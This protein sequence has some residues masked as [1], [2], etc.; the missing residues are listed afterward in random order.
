M[1]Q[2]LH[3]YSYSDNFFSLLPGETKEIEISFAREDYSGGPVILSVKGMNTGVQN[4][5]VNLEISSLMDTEQG[6]DP[7]IILDRLT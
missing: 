6:K 7:N 2:L 1:E 5:T 4:F 3:R